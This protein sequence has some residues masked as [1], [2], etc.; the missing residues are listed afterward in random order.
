MNGSG[1]TGSAGLGEITGVVWA[2]SPGQ[3]SYDPGDTILAGVTV[4]LEDASGNILAT[5]T[6]GAD[7]SY[8]F[9]DLNSGTYQVVAVETNPQFDPY[10]TTGAFSLAPGQTT[11]A[12]VGVNSNP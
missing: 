5:T 3:Q 12:A 11:F 10:N 6:S 2:L 8:D 1:T 4:D 9:S 7:G